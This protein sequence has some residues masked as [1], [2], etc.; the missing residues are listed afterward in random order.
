MTLQ[1]R[2][3]EAKREDIPELLSLYNNFT[4]MFV[5]PASRNAGN[6]R[7]ELRRKDSI[8]WVATD[9]QGRIAGYIHADFDKRFQRGQ[10][11]E[12]L[13]HSDYDFD[14]VARPLAKKIYNIF[15]DKKVLSIRAHS[16][17]NPGFDKIFPALGFFESE[18]MGVFMYAILNVQK[19]LDELQPVLIGR[20]NDSVEKSILLQIECEGSSIFIQKINGAIQPFV[21]TNQPVDF[22]VILTREILMKLVFGIANPLESLKAG[23]LK[24]E[25]ELSGQKTNQILKTLFPKKQFLIMDHW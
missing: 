15:V 11:S 7:R 6:F 9:H 24:I 2:L 13:V 10:F 4:K 16:M 14:Q 8:N 1:L 3:R 20:L 5:G 17:R 22:R 19:F 25:T 23:Q 12:I 18:S 21:Y